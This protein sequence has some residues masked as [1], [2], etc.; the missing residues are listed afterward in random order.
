MEGRSSWTWLFVVGAPVVIIAGGIAYG[1]WPSR[2]P[3]APKT[4]DALPVG[5]ASPPSPP[6][7]A[8]ADGPLEIK[9]TTIGTGA[10]AHAGDNVSV[11]YVGT[12]IDGTEFDSS[13]K[14]GDHTFDFD[15]GA[16]RV[17][18]G[19]DQGVVGM[20]VGGKRHLKIPPSLAYGA[21]GFPPIIPPSSTLIFDIELLDVKPKP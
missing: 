16:G 19:W 9:D 2:A 10:T 15:L 8:S 4:Y 1:V 5:D 3:G 17:I 12:L 13:R 7:D 6:E 20:K 18:K 11:H 14:H 21:R